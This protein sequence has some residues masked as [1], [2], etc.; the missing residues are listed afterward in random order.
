[1]PCYIGLFR[2]CIAAME[3]KMG[4]THWGLGFGS[5]SSN[6]G[7]GEIM[8]FVILLASFQSCQF[9]PSR[10]CVLTLGCISLRQT[11]AAHVRARSLQ[12]CMRNNNRLTDGTLPHTNMETHIV[13]LQR[14]HSLYRAL[15]GFPC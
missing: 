4:T 9:L 10:L 3:K 6:T 12:H 14:D 2:H 13:P 7:S 11:L 15:F 1:M 5:K 8:L